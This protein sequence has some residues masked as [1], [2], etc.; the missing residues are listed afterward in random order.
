VYFQRSQK[1]LICGKNIY[2]LI[3][4]FRSTGFDFNGT[5][6]APRTSTGV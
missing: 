2:Y 1:H 4:I 6:I 5:V 3:C